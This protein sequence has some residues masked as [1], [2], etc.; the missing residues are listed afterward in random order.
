MVVLLIILQS[1]KETIRMYTLI[2]P[3]RSR[4][5]WEKFRQ[6]LVTN[7]SCYIIVDGK[8]N[9]DTK[10]I[11]LNFNDVNKSIERMKKTDYVRL[12]SSRTMPIPPHFAINFLDANKAILLE[13]IVIDN[14]LQEI[15]NAVNLIIQLSFY[16]NPALMELRIPLIIDNIIEEDVNV[17]TD[18][19]NQYMLI[20]RKI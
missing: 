5:F 19:M 14:N 3:N 6:D 1:L 2:D 10:N 9:F 8:Q 11:L 18:N 17:I 12:G 15:S 4:N 20:K 16:E 7:R 13:L